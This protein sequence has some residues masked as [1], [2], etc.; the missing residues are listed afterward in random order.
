MRSCRRRPDSV[1]PP[2]SAGCRAGS[3]RRWTCRCDLWRGDTERNR[4]SLGHQGMGSLPPVRK[5]RGTEPPADLHGLLMTGPMG[6]SVGIK[7]IKII[8]SHAECVTCYFTS[9]L[10]E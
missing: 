7:G 6:P 3:W 8:R 9:L 1:R 5:P 2:A 10:H 4:L